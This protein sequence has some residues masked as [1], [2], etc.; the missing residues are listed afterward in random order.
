MGASEDDGWRTTEEA[1]WQ[2]APGL[3]VAQVTEVL[4]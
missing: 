4:A 2:L 3:R 1:G